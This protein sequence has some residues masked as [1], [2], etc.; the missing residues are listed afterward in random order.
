MT[1]T[2]RRSQ[3]SEYF[4]LSV[5]VRVCARSNRKKVRE[6]QAY[7]CQKTGSQLESKIVCLQVDLRSL[8]SLRLRRGKRET[9]KYSLTQQQNNNTRRQQN[10]NTLTREFV[11]IKFFKKG[12]TSI[13]PFTLSV[14]VCLQI[15]LRP[16]EHKI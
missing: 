11:K 6:N 10:N 15:E 3:T 2:P 7:Q 1:A 4:R 16:F 8:A 12:V 5:D 9:D 14:S 13:S